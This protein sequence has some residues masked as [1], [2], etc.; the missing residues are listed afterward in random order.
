[1]CI[2]LDWLWL[3]WHGHLNDRLPNTY[4]KNILLSLHILP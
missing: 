4:H 1:M 3:L 2:E